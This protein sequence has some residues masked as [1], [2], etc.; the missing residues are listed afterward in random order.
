MNI[1]MFPS[2]ILTWVRRKNCKT[3]NSQIESRAHLSI[4]ASM[5]WKVGVQNGWPWAKITV[6]QAGFLIEAQ[7]WNLFSFWPLESA[8]IPCFMS[9]PAM[10]VKSVLSYLWA[11]LPLSSPPFIFTDLCGYIGPTRVTKNLLSISRSID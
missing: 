9:K 3:N 10:L 8:S 2:L 7:G 11:T 6:S 1:W 4:W 5:V